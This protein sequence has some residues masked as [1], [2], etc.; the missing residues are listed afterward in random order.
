VAM[1]LKNYLEKAVNDPHYKK[2]VDEGF[3]AEPKKFRKDIQKWQTHFQKW[4]GAAL[5]KEEN[6]I[7]TISDL[8]RKAANELTKLEK[9]M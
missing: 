2:K 5:A 1:N 9:I 8:L 3:K 6:Y 4:G 7:D